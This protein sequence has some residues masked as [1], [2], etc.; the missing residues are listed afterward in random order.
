[1]KI[2]KLPPVPAGKDSDE[3]QAAKYIAA[4]I[5]QGLP[6]EYFA[7][8]MNIID[9]EKVEEAAQMTL[10]QLTDWFRRDQ[11]ARQILDR[12]PQFPQFCADLHRAAREMYPPRQAN[13]G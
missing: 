6:G 12:V 11:T 2:R 5:S 9:A 8:L 10:H 3:I 7:R 1:M 4:C 13:A